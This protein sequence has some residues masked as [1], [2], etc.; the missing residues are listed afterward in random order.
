LEKSY[1]YDTAIK[2]NKTSDKKEHLKVDSK[3]GIL[4]MSKE[5]I[6]IKM[7]IKCFILIIKKAMKLNET[8][9]SQL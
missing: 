8:I 1:W 3:N 6:F 2:K 7:Y 5:K 4:L 9:R